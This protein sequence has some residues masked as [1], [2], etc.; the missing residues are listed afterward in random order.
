MSWRFR[1]GWGPTR[2]G[3]EAPLLIPIW[4][5]SS[6]SEERVDLMVPIKRQLG[7]HQGGGIEC[8]GLG[9]VEDRIDDWRGEEVQPDHP[10]DPGIVDP[11][12]AGERGDVGVAGCKPRPP[13]SSLDQQLDQ[14]RV[15]CPRG[16]RSAVV[17]D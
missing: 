4:Q 8:C 13:L 14:G 12:A 16:R 7:S 2:S 11:L 1:R 6:G 3:A 10:R 15:G 9:S 17:V 5:K